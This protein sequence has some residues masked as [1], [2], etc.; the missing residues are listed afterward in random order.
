MDA[1]NLDAQ[2][3][4]NDMPMFLTMP[5]AMMPQVSYHCSHQHNEGAWLL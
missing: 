2:L 3:Q 1:D 4:L 5:D